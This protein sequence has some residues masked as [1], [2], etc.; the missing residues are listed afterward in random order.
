MR[1]NQYDKN[2]LRR[3]RHGKIWSAIVNVWTTSSVFACDNSTTSFKRMGIITTD[4]GLTRDLATNHRLLVI[5]R[6][7][8]TMMS[9]SNISNAKPGWVDFWNITTARRRKLTGQRI[10]FQFTLANHLSCAY[11]GDPTTLAGFDPSTAKIQRRPAIEFSCRQVLSGG[12]QTR[13][14]FWTPAVSA[15]GPRHTSPVYPPGCSTNPIGH[16]W[17][18]K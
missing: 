13:P 5:S 1:D 4:F 9:T 12:C 18:W 11:H 17:Y 6:Y 3:N 15:R 8:T 7:P 10:N 2:V 16:N 14:T